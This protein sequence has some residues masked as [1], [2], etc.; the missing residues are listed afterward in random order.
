MEHCR[1][2]R[3]NPYEENV[4]NIT[5]ENSQI[6]NAT[7]SVST[8]MNKSNKISKNKR[9]TNLNRKNSKVKKLKWDY[10]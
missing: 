8:K 2:I 9:K 5:K 10:V 3:L 4:N 1:K 6:I 7:L